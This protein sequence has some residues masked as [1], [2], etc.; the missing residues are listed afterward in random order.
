ML[1]CCPLPDSTLLPFEPSSCI[2]L[3][4]CPLRSPLSP[5][6]RSMSPPSSQKFS[7]F[8]S[9]VQTVLLRND[10]WDE[11]EGVCYV[12]PATVRS[13][14][15]PGYGNS[16]VAVPSERPPSLSVSSRSSWKG[17]SR[18]G[19]SFRLSPGWCI[20]SSRAWCVAA[21]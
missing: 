8:S 17:G 6:N 14:L 5:R 20:V 12:V 11:E 9:Q 19:P 21:R 4:A 3:A 1:A 18:A 10:D 2:S 7:Q 13:W 16:I 15:Q